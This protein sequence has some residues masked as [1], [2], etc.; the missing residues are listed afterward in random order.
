MEEKNSVHGAM[1]YPSGN[2]E[3]EFS[4]LCPQS[5]T[6]APFAP[7]A[8]DVHGAVPKSAWPDLRLC[9]YREQ[10]KWIVCMC[11][12]FIANTNEK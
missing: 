12:I 10:I 6:P 7:C 1:S 3:L 5:P 2:P 4:P 8:K 9:G 11:S